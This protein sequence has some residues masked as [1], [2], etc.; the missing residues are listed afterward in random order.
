MNTPEYLHRAPR[1]PEAAIATL[2]TRQLVEL[3]D[4]FTN[5][6]ANVARI[7]NPWLQVIAAERSQR[8]RSL[9]AIQEYRPPTVEGPDY[10]IERGPSGYL[11]QARRVN[12]AAALNPDQMSK[13]PDKALLGNLV[14]SYILPELRRASGDNI[15]LTSDEMLDFLTANLQGIVLMPHS[16][17]ATSYENAK[18]EVIRSHIPDASPAQPHKL[19]YQVHKLGF[20]KENIENLRI[21]VE[22]VPFRSAAPDF[23][24]IPRTHQNNILLAIT[25]EWVKMCTYID[26]ID[27]TLLPQYAHPPQMPLAYR[28][29]LELH[30]AVARNSLVPREEIC[31][32]FLQRPQEFE[33]ELRRKSEITAR[34]LNTAKSLARAAVNN[35]FV[36]NLAVTPPLSRPE[37]NRTENN[38]TTTPETPEENSNL[39][40]IQAL[41]NDPDVNSAVLEAGL[42]ES[43]LVTKPDNLIPARQFDKLID[44]HIEL[45]G[46]AL[47]ENM[48]EKDNGGLRLTGW[49]TVE[50]GALLRGKFYGNLRN[51]KIT[52]APVTDERL[53]NNLRLQIAGLPP[54][55]EALQLLLEAE[56]KPTGKKSEPVLLSLVILI[57][58][59]QAGQR[60]HDTLGKIKTG[61]R[62]TGPEVAR[63][64]NDKA[65]AVGRANEFINRSKPL[66]AGLPGLGRSR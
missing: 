46:R 9:K 56:L 17:A 8:A 26:T 31:R 44:K 29:F 35:Q 5:S 23:Y 38:T 49:D 59:A 21:A 4:R 57:R 65:M 6:E 48:D 2:E 24:Q 16:A 42:G 53:L 33:E 37:A 27:P 36:Q 25:D 62:T 13:L 52:Q 3:D 64:L 41:L 12:L 45:I 58:K 43:V 55:G 19:K 28:S 22:D 63:K 50:A 10:D 66:S 34:N 18:Y 32:I 54:T 47:W 61:L 20:K 1:D 7:D 39:I 51:L 30:Q 15:D 40:E 11:E 60:N 14:Q